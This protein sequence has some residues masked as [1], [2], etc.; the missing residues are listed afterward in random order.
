MVQKMK[1]E[2][3]IR[4]RITDIERRLIDDDGNP[5]DDAY[6]D[7]GEQAELNTLKWVVGDA[8]Y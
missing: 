1:S 2:R 6:L 4:D 7:E 8:D 3:Q 5:A